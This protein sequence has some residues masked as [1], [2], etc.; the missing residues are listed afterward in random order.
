MKKLVV[1]LIGAGCVTLLHAQANAACGVLKVSKGDVKIASGGTKASAPAPE[2]TKICS[3][4]TII[5]GVDSRAKIVMEDGNQLNIS[6]KSKIIIENYEFK[7]AE[8]KKKVLLN[9][10]SGKVRATT[11]PNMYADKAKNGE[12]NSFQVKT[13]SAVA[14]VRGT[15]F[16]TGYNPST[17]KAEVVTFSGKVEVGQPGPGGQILNSVHVTPGQKT[18]VAFGKP[19][20]PPKAIPR[21]QFQQMN[22]ETKADSPTNS[23][24]TSAGSPA[25]GDKSDDKKDDG[26][27]SSDG[28][29]SG[30]G[31]K[32]DATKGDG[33][34]APAGDGK[35]G[36]AKQGADQGPAA[37]SK[38]S[39]ARKQPEGGQQADSGKQPSSGDKNSSGSANAGAPAPGTS[40]S[41]DGSK[42]SG[43][44]SGMA[45]RSPASTV[46]SGGAPQPPKLMTEG[47]SGPGAG[48]NLPN[49]VPPPTIGA[50]PVLPSL[51]VAPPTVPK[52][53]FCDRAV[54]TSPSRVNVKINFGQ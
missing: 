38:Q 9:V 42:G 13:K 1:A 24:E 21:Q 18:E 40:A 32:G 33:G 45:P 25:A 16:L 3:G 34:S 28:A 20:A 39:D 50:L 41:A 7:P 48:A 14:G 12:A 37:D 53:D 44:K 47:P 51:P 22:E 2:G 4:D 5:A 36:D 29:Q 35:Q 10:L 19:P 23:H 6:P 30:D 31:A 26:A 27:K 49:L 54:Q 11:T 8:N 46:N 17:R 15:D 52:C 43:S